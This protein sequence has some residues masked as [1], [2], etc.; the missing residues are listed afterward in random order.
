[1]AFEALC[2]NLYEQEV[3][4][5][6][7]EVAEIESLGEGMDIPND[8]SDEARAAGGAGDFI[9]F[10]YV[11]DVEPVSEAGDLDAFRG[12]VERLLGGLGEAGFDYVTAADFELPGGGRSA[13]PSG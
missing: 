8:D 11:L 3:P 9:C 4:V 6:P 10:P 13:R 1:M 5:F 2:D 7:G 12:A